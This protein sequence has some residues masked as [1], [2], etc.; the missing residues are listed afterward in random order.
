MPDRKHQLE[1]GPFIPL[2][3]HH[4]LLND[5]V[6]M[7]GFETAIARVVTPGAEVLELGGSGTFSAILRSGHGPFSRVFAAGTGVA[8]TACRG[9]L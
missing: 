6:R 9:R 2:H 1:L 3:Y 8:P 5:T 7:R 4:N